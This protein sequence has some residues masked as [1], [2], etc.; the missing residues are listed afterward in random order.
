MVCDKRFSWNPS[1]CEFECDK[2]FRTGEYFDSKTFACRNTLIDQLV[3]ESTSVIDE[4]KIYNETQFHQMNV[5]LAQY[6]L[7]H[8]LCFY[9]Q[10]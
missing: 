6:M 5:L 10:A 1:N 2:L 4:N 3:E 9:Q 7:Y 8:V